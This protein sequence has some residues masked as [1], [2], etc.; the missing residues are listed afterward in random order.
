MV[1]NANSTTTIKKRKETQLRK[2]CRGCYYD[3][4][5]K[6]Y[7]FKDVQGTSPQE[8]PV[9]VENVGC[10]HYKNT[11]LVKLE[12]KHLRLILDKFDGEILSDKYEVYKK[13]YKPYKKKYVKSAHN[14]S[15][16]KDAQ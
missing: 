6:C 8:I 1:I 2:T 12:S 4:D 16:R 11:N 9:S 7:W 15:Y 14:Y 5:D 10:K 3:I 13:P